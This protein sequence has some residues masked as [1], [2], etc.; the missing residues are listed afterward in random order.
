[1]NASPPIRHQAARGHHIRL[2]GVSH[3]Y[4]AVQALRDVHL[5]IA[6]GQLVALL[7]PSGCGKTTLLK[8]IA[9]F[10]FP[11]A[12]EVQVDSENIT[13]MPA[14]ERNVGIVFQNYALFPHM[15]VAR[16]IGY[17]LRA[18]RVSRRVVNERVGDMLS[19]VKMEVFADRYPGEL[20][21]GQQQ[22]V[23]L[24]RA[25]AV[26]PRIMLL[27]EPF[28]ALDRGLRLDMQIEVKKLL[29]G[30]GVT[31]ILVTHDQEEAL[32]MAD[33][34]VVLRDGRV[35][36]VGTAAD[37][38]D[39][40]QTLFVNR[41]L[42]QTNLL[43]GIVEAMSEGAK[44]LALDCGARMPMIGDFKAGR[45]IV[46]SV[47]PENLVETTTPE[48]GAIPATVKLN[49]PLG[50]SDV[51]EFETCCGTP[52]RR[53]RPHRSGSLPDPPGTMVHL[54][55]QDLA[56]CNVFYADNQGATEHN[57]T[58]KMETEP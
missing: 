7:G 1:M 4:G 22:R 10:V 24:A 5:T 32:S 47:R 34:I 56:A 42:G 38:Y 3:S 15:T 37:L 58:Q 44:L 17:G 45:R 41:F 27:D 49:M 31:S 46:V 33:R 18:R 43:P 20:S 9:G 23:A 52:I 53:F 8:I 25:L 55:V 28:S 30:H 21:G 40:P 51:T 6:P 13:H 36:Q 29:R 26:Q 16:N 57:L 11:T 39:R 50:S 12:G 2:G 14:G 48:A 19:L 35:E 54:K